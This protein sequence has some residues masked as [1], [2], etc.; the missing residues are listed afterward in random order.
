MTWLNTPHFQVLED[1]APKYPTWA[2]RN[3]ELDLQSRLSR[4]V[5]QVLP[6]PRNRRSSALRGWHPRPSCDEGRHPRARFF[7]PGNCPHAP[8]L[9][10]TVTCRYLRDPDRRNDRGENRWPRT[11]LKSVP[12]PTALSVI[13]FFSSGTKRERRRRFL[14]FVTSYCSYLVLRSL[15]LLSPN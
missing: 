8:R 7:V 4:G 2:Q 12:I 11:Q 13:S 15:E 1:H 9:Q 5:S 10:C 6:K 14:V 3:E